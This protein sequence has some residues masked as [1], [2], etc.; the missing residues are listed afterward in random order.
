MMTRQGAFVVSVWDGAAQ[1]ITIL[2]GADFVVTVLDV[3]LDQLCVF[4]E[5]LDTYRTS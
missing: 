2:A 4:L 1:V 5:I 3:R